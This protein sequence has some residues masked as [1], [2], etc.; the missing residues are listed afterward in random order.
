L[1]H[2]EELHRASQKPKQLTAHLSVDILSKFTCIN[3]ISLGVIAEVILSEVHTMSVSPIVIGNND[4][5]FPC[6]AYFMLVDSSYQAQ[7]AAESLRF[8][9]RDHVIIF[10]LNNSCPECKLQNTTLFGLEQVVVICSVSDSVYRQDVS[11]DLHVVTNNSKLLQSKASVREDYM[12]RF[13]RV[14]TF[15]C[16]P[17]SYGTGNGVNSSSYKERSKHN[18]DRLIFKECRILLQMIIFLYLRAFANF[19]VTA[20]SFVKSVRPSARKN[21]APTG[22]VFMIFYIRIFFENL[23]RRFKFH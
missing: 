15:N 6:Q 1:F 14:S 21:S 10:N 18:L 9:S 8:Q 17:Y 12:G 20:T 22:R 3:F 7:V 5:D 11:G 16:P 4:M 23:Q 19:L 2:K 13:L